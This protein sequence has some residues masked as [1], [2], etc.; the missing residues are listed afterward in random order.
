MLGLVI[1]EGRAVSI[2]DERRVI[3]YDDVRGP[4]GD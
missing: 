3:Y 4:S 2:D 1:G